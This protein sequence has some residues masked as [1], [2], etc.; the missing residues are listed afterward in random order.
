MQYTFF[1]RRTY[2]LTRINNI[3]TDCKTNNAPCQRRHVLDSNSS[4]RRPISSIFPVI[5][6]P[7]SEKRVCICSNKSCTNTARSG[8][9]CPPPPP[10]PPLET[11]LEVS[12]AEILWLKDVVVVVTSPPR[13]EDS[14]VW[15]G[16]LV[17][18][19]LALLLLF[20]NAMVGYE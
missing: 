1:T 11:L 15:D 6:S 4:I 2:K 17:V 12:I 19:L 14:K 18:L 16:V 5:E 10:L 8:D 20:P 3:K 9:G 13:L 7:I